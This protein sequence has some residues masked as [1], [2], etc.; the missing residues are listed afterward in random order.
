MSIINEVAERQTKDE[1]IEAL[2]EK[3]EALTKE[4]NEA[5]RKARLFENLA[6]SLAAEV[7]AWNVGETQFAPLLRQARKILA[8]NEPETA[9]T[10]PTTGA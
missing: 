6:C 1:A 3:V 10:A 7:V 5:N 8:Y 4:R 9:T 2:R